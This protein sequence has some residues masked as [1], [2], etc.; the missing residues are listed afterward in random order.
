MSADLT[1]LSGF[2]PGEIPSPPKQRM[3]K[4]EFL[5]WALATRTNAEWVDGE[6]ILMA[7]ANRDHMECR[8]WF[9][10]VLTLFVR[11]H[12]LGV[13]GDDMFVDL[14]GQ[15]TLRVPDTFFVRRERQHI[16]EQTVVPQPPDMAVEVVSPDSRTRDRDEKLREYAD[17]GITEYWIID[18]MLEQV[19]VFV[20]D[21]T[22]KYR[23]VASVDGA[24]HSTVVMGFW[25]RPEWMWRETRVDE[26]EA[27]RL[28]TDT[29]N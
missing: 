1:N 20:L 17:F 23:S 18:P 10:D 15:R 21:A 22:K 13:V 27:Y 25:I 14:D 7:A 12:R 16:I 6:V 3:S 19:E 9:D 5:E 29:T 28:I 8:R 2:S 4:E 11:R 24:F 26:D